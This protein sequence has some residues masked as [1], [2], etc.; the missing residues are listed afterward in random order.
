MGRRNSIVITKK[1]ADAA[2]PEKHGQWLWD[3]Q[4]LGLGL[5][6]RESGHRSWIFRWYIGKREVRPVIGVYKDSDL[7]EVRMSIDDARKKARAWRAEIDQGRDPRSQ[8]T[9][10]MT[11]KDHWPQFIEHK[12]QREGLSASTL[13]GYQ[14]HFNTHL[15]HPKHG[16]AGIAVAAVIRKDIIRLQRAV[17]DQGRRNAE[18][19]YDKAVADERPTEYLDKLEAK[20]PTAG[21]GEANSVVLTLQSFFS[22]MVASGE[23]DSSPAAKIEKLPT[24][25]RA[26]GSILDRDDALDAIAQIRKH[27][28]NDGHRDALLLLLLSAQRTSDILT[29]HWPDV[30][31]DDPDLPLPYLEIEHH[32]SRRR[33][34]DAKR[35]PLGPEALAILL[36]RWPGS[37][38]TPRRTPEGWVVEDE[39]GDGTVYPM[40]PCST[41]AHRV[42]KVEAPV[43]P[44]KD[45]TK[46]LT[47]LWHAWRECAEHSAR[48]RVRASD[49]HGLRHAGASLMKA[50]GVPEDLIQQVLHHGSIHTT[51]SIYLHATADVL[52]RLGE[53]L[54][55]GFTGR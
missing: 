1:V 41:W 35:I 22:W 49:V 34:K 4:Q 20:L 46:P 6:L 9:K 43:F 12:K 42:P 51:R 45:P 27:A 23:F 54:A 24:A 5:R 26:P 18:K 7:S 14:R 21:N 55:P 31:L 47:D 44:G 8:S 48:P 53:L 11:I 50:A 29:L 28:G 37:P 2:T 17:A 30:V 40:F 10:G 33:T 15:A 19:L 3:A 39:I 52:G 25:G 13:E 36:E 32:K 38:L 16:I